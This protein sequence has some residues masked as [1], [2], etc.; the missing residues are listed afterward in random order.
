MLNDNRQAYGL[1][2][3]VSLVTGMGI[4]L[5]FRNTNMLLFDW[6]PKLEFFRDKLISIEFSC[7]SSMLL[8]N[9]PDSLWFLSGILF[10]RFIW[11]HSPKEQSVYIFCFYFLGLTFEI[12]QL[13]S[14]IPGTFDYLDILFMGIAAFVEGLLYYFLANRRLGW[15]KGKKEGC[16]LLQ[17]PHS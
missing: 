13:S 5:L 1:A 12:S 16:I 10:I 7:I 11:F 4:Y 9:L 3:L 6:A 2:S 14:I 17:H 8:Y 15:E